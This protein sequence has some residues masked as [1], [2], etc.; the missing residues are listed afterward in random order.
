MTQFKDKAHKQGSD[1]ASV[2]LFTYPILQA[3]DILLYQPH[4]V[5][6]G[7]DQR[8]H[9]E[10]SRDL[11][12]RFNSRFGDTFTVP[13]PFIQKESAKIYDLQH[14]TAKMSKSAESPAGLINLLDE[15][16]VTAKRIK[17]A[18]TDTETE[19]RFDREAK[20]GVSNLL[21]IYSSITGQSVDALVTAYEG[22]MY[23]HLKADLAEVVTEHLTP[24]RNRAKELLDDPAELDRLLG[25][26]ADKAR[27][28]ASLTLRDV[29]AKVGFLPYAGAQG[30][31]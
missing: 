12:Q 29:Y 23:G 4:G 18:V 28:I 9:V 10:L 22:K 13:Q 6:V 26:G 7:E 5:P 19:I 8:Q 25:L 2:G 21:T 24:I 20:P 15:P 16:K 31:R 14:P 17:S 1:H 11:A 30:V 27:E 3:A